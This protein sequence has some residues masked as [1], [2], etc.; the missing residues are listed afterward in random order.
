MQNLDENERNPAINILFS[1][2]DRYGKIYRIIAVRGL[3][4]T[5][6]RG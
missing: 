1:N 5:Y 3:Y 2:I 6:E 4:S